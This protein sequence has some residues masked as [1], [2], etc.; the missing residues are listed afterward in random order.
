MGLV[1]RKGEGAGK[2]WREKKN[3]VKEEPIVS[4]CVAVSSGCLRVGGFNGNQH[5]VFTRK[6]SQRNVS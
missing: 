4:F 5:K 6:I 3:K 2:F 1:W